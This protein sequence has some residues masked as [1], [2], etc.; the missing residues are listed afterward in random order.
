MAEA[1]KVE[2]KKPAKPPEE[3]TPSALALHKVGP[4]GD[5]EAYQAEKRKHRWG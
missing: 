4:D 5:G 3:P 2:E 1:K